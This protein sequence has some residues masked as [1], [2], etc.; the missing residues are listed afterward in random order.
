M[1]ILFE[2]HFVPWK[3]FPR[4]TKFE[5]EDRIGGFIRR[6]VVRQKAVDATETPKIGEVDE[7]YRLTI[8]VTNGRYTF[9]SGPVP[10]EEPGTVYITANSSYGVMH[11]FT[12]LT[13]L[14]YYSNNNR[15]ELLYTSG[16]RG[17]VYSSLAPIEIDDKPQFPHR[18]LN[19]DVARQWYPKADILKTID[20]LAWN[21]MNKLHLHVTDSQ[22]WPLEI[23]AL[24]E[25]ARKG[26]YADGLT[27][28]PD[29]L[30][31]ILTWGK[32]RGVEVIVEIDMP[33]HT[34]S[35]AEAFPDLIAGKNVQPDWSKYAAQPP[36]GS[37]KL[38]ND[39]VKN[40]LTTMFGDLLPRLRGHSQYFH[41]GG[42]E[43]N[44]NVYLF[45]EGIKSNETSVLQ[46]ALQDFVSHAHAQLAKTGTTPFVW[47]EMLLEW[48]LTLPK[49]T[50][51]QTWLSPDSPKKVIEKGYRTITGN[52]MYWYLDCGNGQWLDFLPQ[53]YA[54]FFPFNDYCAPKKSW[55]LSKNPPPSFLLFS[56]KKIRLKLETPTT[57]STATTRPQA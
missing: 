16:H 38:K 19:L 34:T 45:D 50:I 18:G 9:G 31:D 5:P 11:A 3:F 53:S 25:L 35:I 10:Q 4:G 49:D 29:D 17:G 41:T 30:Q 47:E 24:P 21:K 33:G 48:N 52:Y 27:Y 8:P 26:C 42:D 13:Q 37:L 20:A 36:S 55:R 39:K 23:P 12:T 44:K 54:K 7:S 57:Q 46:P 51:V 32:K 1:A 2:E 22:S 40:F 6:V 43:V 28:S 56:L 15:A 14:F